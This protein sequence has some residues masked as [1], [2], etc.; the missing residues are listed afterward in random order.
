M[1]NCI[2][3]MNFFVVFAASFFAQNRCAKKDIHSLTD[4]AKLSCIFQW[5]FAPEGRRYACAVI[6][7]WT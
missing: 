4:V 1:T 6:L 7:T 2:I 3:H 5:T